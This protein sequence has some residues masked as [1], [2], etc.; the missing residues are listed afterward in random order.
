MAIWKVTMDGKDV[1]FGEAKRKR[2]TP[3]GCNEPFKRWYWCPRRQWFNK[4]PCPFVNKN[5]CD[6]YRRMCGNL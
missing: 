5:E 3:S 6:T 4:I 1:Q 2:I